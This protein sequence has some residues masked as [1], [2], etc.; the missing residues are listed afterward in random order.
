MSSFNPPTFH[1]WCDTEML[2]GALSSFAISDVCSY[3]VWWTL[4]S[5]NSHVGV[6]LEIS[7]DFSFSI[8]AYYL[9]SE[10]LKV[11]FQSSLNTTYNIFIY[12]IWN[13]SA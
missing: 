5:M 9:C 4:M 10:V 6:H 1:P 12:M 3:V 2:L 13:G 7:I 8:S 11:I